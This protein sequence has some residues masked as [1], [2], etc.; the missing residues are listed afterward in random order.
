MT[1]GDLSY[2][3][4]QVELN[5]GRSVA[6]L[7]KLLQETLGP[8]RSLLRLPTTPH[9]WMSTNSQQRNTA[10]QTFTLLPQSPTHVKVM[11]YNIHCVDVHFKADGLVAIRD[12]SLSMF[13]QTKVLND[14]EPIRGFKAFLFKYVD[15]AALSRRTSQTEDDNPP[16]PLPMEQEGAGLKFSG[17]GAGA[18]GA[19]SPHPGGGALLQSPPSH[20]QPSAGASPAPSPAQFPAPSPLGVGSP[21]TAASPLGQVSNIKTSYNHIL[22]YCAMAGRLSPAPAV[23]PARGLLPEPRHGVLRRPPDPG[24]DPA[25]EAVGRLHAHAA[26][27][28]GV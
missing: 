15:E 25:P 26:H 5:K 14:L 12:G 20:R 24:Q 2:L 21:F 10:I 13:D 3:C 19:M 18:G 23:A 16:S 27:R 11:F 4:L 28:Q 9:K 8:V 7:G 22:H 1:H 17:S 6:K